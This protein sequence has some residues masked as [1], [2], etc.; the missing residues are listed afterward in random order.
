MKM[1]KGEGLKAVFG[2][3]LEVEGSARSVPKTPTRKL[4]GPKMNS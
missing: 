4:K 2:N 3:S 1:P